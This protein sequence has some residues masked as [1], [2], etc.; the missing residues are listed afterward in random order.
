MQQIIDYLKETYAPLAIVTYGS[1][2]C[3]TNDEYSDFDCLVLV[4]EK[5]KR[6][7]DSV[8]NGIP[9]DCFLFTPEEAAEE[10]PDT[11]L[12]VYDG[13]I[14]LDTDNLAL[15]L[16]NRV[17]QYVAEHSKIDEE[18]KQFI[19]SWI[20]KTM[21][22]AEKQDDEGSYRALAFLWESLTDYYLL[23]DMYYFGSKKAV[24]YLKAED[25]TGY[26]LYHAAI[27][28]RTNEAI[29]RWAEYVANVCQG[30]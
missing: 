9:L 16:K 25:P 30:V 28:E 5:T 11:F 8:I 10:D 18:E 23:R 7:D 1:F 14:L 15:N 21:R 19:A 4:K 29:A 22:R 24:A 26:S 6:H 27:T 12:T 20:A 13:N 3:G 2:A 17:R